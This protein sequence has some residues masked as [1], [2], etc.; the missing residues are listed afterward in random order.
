[1]LYFGA[2]IWLAFTP[3]SVTNRG[4]WYLSGA[5]F[6]PVGILLLM[7]FGRRR[8]WVAIGFGALGAAWLEAGQSVWMPLGY[9]EPWD[10]VWASAGSI[11]GVLLAYGLS[12]PRML[13]A[14]R[15][16]RSHET[17]RIVAQAGN[18]EI[19]QD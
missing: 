12:S 1:M 8:W 7:M 18:R 9:A 16:Q 5:S 3:G 10:V 13:A 17:P 11:A 15:E 6:V 2:V 4:V 14:A 19:P